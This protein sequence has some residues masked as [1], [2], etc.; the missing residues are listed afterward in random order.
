MSAHPRERRHGQ[1]SYV[2]RSLI[3]RATIPSALLAVSSF[4]LPPKAAAQGWTVN[5]AV[6]GLVTA[7]SNANHATGDAARKDVIASVQPSFY[8]V[9]QSG[10]YRVHATVGAELVA[11]ANATQPNR[12]YP[13]IL[14]NGNA[15]LNP[16]FLFVDAAVSSRVAE[17]DAYASRTDSGTTEN[18]QILTTYRISPYINYDISPASS[19]YARHEEMYS[20]SN[21]VLAANQLF[22]NTEVRLTR[23]PLPFG[24][25]LEFANHTVQY[26]GAGDSKWSNDTL[27][28]KGDIGIAGELVFGPTLGAEHTKLF[29]E[30]HNDALYGAHL[31]WIPNERVSLKAEVEK[32]FFGV[33]GRL[34]A[35]HRSP[36]MSFALQVERIPVTTASSLGVGASGSN[37]STFLDS[38]L[39]TRFPDPAAR[40]AIVTDLVTSRGLQ[41]KLQGSV[42][43]LAEY[44]QLQDRAQATWMLL[45]SR[46]IIVFS[47]YGQRL[48]QLTREGETGGGL[49]IA[50]Q[51]NRQVGGTVSLNRRL[52]PQVTLDMSAVFSKIDGL[53]LRK[54][55]ASRDRTFRISAVRMIA[56]RTGVSIGMQY[57]NFDSNIP[58]IDSYRA[59]SA[60]VG[61][62][63]RF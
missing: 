33:G 30:D 4:F 3:R 44:A 15:T 26:S 14:A 12:A 61:M 6:D 48:R 2:A 42:D 46:N 59:P 36:F 11:Y 7:S 9:G 10:F 28:A 17:R 20:H 50:N 21:A 45:G 35:H 57:T 37:L 32:R 29:L 41:T 51:D 27:K 54:G 55:D 58:G 23:K 43:I 5:S 18:R 63:H 34:D 49:V 8:L 60:F 1:G 39:T 25:S 24:G 13:L 19:F 16:R 40:Q 53:G 56:P 38:I 62:N 52:S 47:I 22:S 31:T